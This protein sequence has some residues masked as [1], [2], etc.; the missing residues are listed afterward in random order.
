MPQIT[1]YICVADA[2]TAIDW[3]VATLG[4][5]RTS[6]VGIATYRAHHD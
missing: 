6:N 5:A 4:A 1:P 3:Y 2:L